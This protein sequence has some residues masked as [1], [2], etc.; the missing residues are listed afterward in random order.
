MNLE[1]PSHSSTA[2]VRVLNV[3]ARIHGWWGPAEA[4]GAGGTV[5]TAAATSETTTTA[6]SV[7]TTTTAH[8][9]W[10]SGGSIHVGDAAGVDG[11]EEDDEDVHDQGAGAAMDLDGRARGRGGEDHEG[12]GGLGDHDGRGEGGADGEPVEDVG[13]SLQVRDRLAFLDVLQV[14]H[15]HDGADEP[16]GTRQ[17]EQEEVDVLLKL[18]RRRDQTLLGIGGS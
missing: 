2:H 16:E 10:L 17:G 8:G 15:E 5:G 4:A 6:T 1:I 14:Q 12:R 13:Q 11:G 7:A 9:A 18:K 3:T